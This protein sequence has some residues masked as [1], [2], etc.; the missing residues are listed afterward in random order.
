[1]RSV[2]LTSIIMIVLLA[3]PGC[4]SF[5]AAGF[6]FDTSYD[7]ENKAVVVSVSGSLDEL[8]CS[9]GKLIRLHRWTSWEKCS[10]A[11]V[12]EVTVDGGA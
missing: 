9:V 12:V 3:A 7:P 10:D 6:G 4:A 2:F 8:T 1:M 11:P 5:S